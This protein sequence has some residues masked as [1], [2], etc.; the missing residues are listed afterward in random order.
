MHIPWAIVP[1]SCALLLSGC[2]IAPTFTSSSTSS[3][4][5]AA[6]KGR[7]HG[8]Q[9]P[10]VG[11]SVYLYAANTTGYGKASVSLLASPGYVTTDGNGNFSITGDYTCPGASTQV[12]LYSIGGNPGAGTNPEAA[13]LAGL[14]SCGSL[15]SSTFVT[16]NEVSTV[17][18]AY[19]IAGFTT[20]ALHVSSSGSTLALQGIANAFAMIPNLETLS[21]G[22]PLAT[23]PAGNGTLWRS[24]AVTISVADILAACINTNGSMASGMPCNTLL[25]TA[26]AGGTTGTQPAETATAAINIAHYP[27]SNLSTLMTLQTATSPFQPYLTFVPGDLTMG[28]NYTASWLQLPYALAVDAEGDVWVT[29]EGATAGELYASSHSGGS[30]SWSAPYSGGG[31]LNGFPY[32]A[33]VDTSGNLWVALLTNGSGGALAELS[34]TGS[35]ISPSSGYPGDSNNSYSVSIDA[36]GNAWLP[37]Y[38]TNALFEYI[39]GT[40]FANTT[41]FTGGGIS[42]PY[43][44]AI[45]ASGNIWATNQGYKGLSEFSSSG[46]ANASSPFSGTAAGMTEPGEGIAVDASGNIWAVDFAV[47]TEFNSSGGAVSGSG[48]YSGGG[49]ATPVALAIDSAG[50]VFTS[51][52]TNDDIS[53]FSSTGMPLSPSNYGYEPVSGLDDL[54]GIAIDGSGNVWFA[55]EDGN[56]L[57]EAVGLASPVVTPV[58]ANL[59]APYGSHAVNLP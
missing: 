5:G 39:P 37:S 4:P 34:S 13:L 50:N 26:L 2:S 53:E 11:A 15:S 18:T 57:V 33:A 10:I 42:D 56:S 46:V 40:G 32:G 47:L 22:V 35:P 24:G 54:A 21:T 48:G 38:G 29:A 1:Y 59:K 58:V 51:N 6:L 19:A 12:Y 14:G 3:A 31:L 36:S 45:D 7:V 23:T 27:G 16:V 8:G 30:N 43:I 44:L 49:L 28:I 25:T 20:D 52:H 41:G 17:A 55:N 9:Q